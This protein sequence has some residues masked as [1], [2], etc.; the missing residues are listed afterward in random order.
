M[1]VAANPQLSELEFVVAKDF[2][3]SADRIVLGV[4]E[5]ICVVDVEP[6]FRSEE[7]RSIWSVFGARVTGKPAEVRKCEWF[8]LLIAYG[9]GG[10]LLRD[11]YG[12]LCGR[13][14]SH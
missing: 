14:G 10:L 1:K 3:R 6:D 5:V 13:S 2:A 11:G 7:L 12:R 4:I 8:R 9:S